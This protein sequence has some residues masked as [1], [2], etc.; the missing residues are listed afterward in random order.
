MSKSASIRN[1]LTSTKIIGM[2]LGLTNTYKIIKKLKLNV[3]DSKIIHVAGSN[4]KGTVC[5]LMATTLTMMKKSNL[6]FSSPHLCKVEERIR[7]NGKP[8]DSIIFDGALMNIKSAANEEN[9]QLTFFETTFLAALIVAKQS[10]VEYLILETGL[11]GRLDATRCTN[12]D[13]AILTAI[14]KEHSD[15]LGDDIYQI[16][17]EKAAIARP[18]KPII[19]REMPIFNYRK[20]VKEI[21]HNC[22]QVILEEE[23]LP[24]ICHFVKVPGNTTINVEAKLLVQNAFNF[25]N[26]ST[27][28]IDCALK[29]L[30][31]PGRLQKLTL[32]NGQTLILDAAHNPSGLAKVSNELISLIQP[33]IKNKKW[34]LIFGTSPQKE[35]DEMVESITEICRKLGPPE[36]YLTKP[37]GGRYPGVETEDLA[38]YPWSYSKIYQF[39]NVKQVLD[40]IIKKQ[41]LQNQPILSIGSL[42]LQGNILNYLQLNTDNDLSLIP[43]KSN[44]TP[45]RRVD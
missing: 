10:K 41:T 22:Q 2:S 33:E 35:M 20:T 13:L 31:W 27:K 1:W 17:A 34:S 16:I 42:Y 4:G 36:L 29:N 32:H 7:I 15:I 25:L 5:A 30:H 3:K 45:S 24:A 21:A 37:Q 26:L 38:N 12:A 40:Y 14:S 44:A 18:G 23:S 19:A 8:C 9:I 39:E 28:K 43:K 11:G 6:L